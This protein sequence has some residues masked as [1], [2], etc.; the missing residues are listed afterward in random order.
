MRALAIR[1]HEEDNPGLI[2]EALEARGFSVDLAMLDET[3]PTP[4][5]DGYDLL[6]ILGSK[7]SVYDSDVEAAWFGRE[8]ALMAEADQRGLPIFG[9]CFGAQALCR[10]RGGV[11][12]RSDQPEVGWYEIEG[13]DGHDIAAG[14]WF[15]F[16]YDAC[17]LPEG[18][19]V[20]ARSPRAVQAFAIDRHV[21]VQFHPEIDDVQ[22]RD[23]LETASG[24]ARDFGHD[25]DELMAF[26]KA[27]V[28][29]ARA[30]ALALVDQVLAHNGLA[31]PK[32]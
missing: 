25:I 15:E 9:I 4:S 6:L 23:W 19:E 12:S 32:A 7:E 13:V 3:T 18:A 26:T 27:E 14:P 21:G 17:D 2:G 5:L 30:R 20:W 1:H 24:E 31:T 8:L 29:A 28:P 11:V 16:H 10:L 22:L